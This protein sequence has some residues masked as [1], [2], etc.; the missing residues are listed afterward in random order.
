MRNG[1]RTSFFRQILRVLRRPAARVSPVSCM[2]D[3]VGATPG[4]YHT[5]LTVLLVVAIVYVFVIHDAHAHRY[6]RCLRRLRSYSGSLRRS[7]A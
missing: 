7:L 3:V 6:R 4:C 2:G 5:L 1:L